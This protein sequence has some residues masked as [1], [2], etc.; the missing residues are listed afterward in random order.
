MGSD[1]ALTVLHATRRAAKNTNFL[2]QTN[3]PLKYC[4]LMLTLQFG[5]IIDVKWRSLNS[6]QLKT[7]SN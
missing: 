1:F 7:A 6:M 4:W 2:L 3:P 5:A